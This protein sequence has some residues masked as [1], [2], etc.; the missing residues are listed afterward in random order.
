MYIGLCFLSREKSSRWFN[1]IMFRKRESIWCLSM[2]RVLAVQDGCGCLWNCSC[3]FARGP[4]CQ[5]VSPCPPPLPSHFINSPSLLPRKSAR[6]AKALEL[7]YVNGRTIFD[8][9]HSWAKS[10]Q[11]GC[12]IILNGNIRTWVKCRE[13]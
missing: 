13:V 11:T 5:L 6:D 2:R 3:Q 7:I 1:A 8:L 4:A 12:C 10:P 9:S